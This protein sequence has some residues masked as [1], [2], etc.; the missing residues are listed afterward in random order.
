MNDD[1]HLG[2]K[3]GLS[4]SN[5]PLHSHLFLL[6]LFLAFSKQLFEPDSRY[7][8]KRSP[9][10]QKCQGFFVYDQHELLFYLVSVRGDSATGL[11][12]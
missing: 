5:F 9:D 7:I 1:L 4:L 6:E 2:Q 3:I 8:S 10:K 11:L 12:S